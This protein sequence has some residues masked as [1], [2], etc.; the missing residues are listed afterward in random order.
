ML[1]RTNEEMR[2]FVYLLE[3]YAY[4]KGRNAGDVLQEW[5]AHGITQEIYDGYFQYHQ[6]RIE[7]AYEDIDSLVATGQ[8][9]SLTY[10]DEGR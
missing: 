2:F 8:H 1:P 9:A 5:D 4:A 7:N 10:A 6:E 3:Y